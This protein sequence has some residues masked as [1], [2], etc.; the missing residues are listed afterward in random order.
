M[1]KLICILFS[2]TV[3]VASMFADK[4]RFYEGGK[5]IDTM[6]V[7]SE[8][9]LKVRVKSNRLCGLPHR[10]PVKVVAIGK[11]ETIDGITAP[12]VEILIPRY[13]C[14]E[15]E[16]PRYG[17]IFGG[18]LSS[19]QAE[20]STKNWKKKDYENYLLNFCS[21]Q[22]EHDDYIFEIYV[23]FFDAKNL[24]RTEYIDGEDG[25]WSVSE[26]NGNS[27]ILKLEYTKNEHY[28]DPD[29]PEA[30]RV[31][32][33]KTIE[34]KMK[35]IDEAHYF[36]E[37]LNKN[38]YGLIAGASETKVSFYLKD[39]NGRSIYDYVGKILNTAD[40][41]R[42]NQSVAIKCGVSVKDTKYERQCHDYWNPI[43]VEHQKKADEMK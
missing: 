38:F 34:H 8:D 1:K 29:D 20:F 31:V 21:W 23:G 36:D 22:K 12:W 25:V 5:V 14:R 35:I 18:Y 9:G 40:A 24:S 7:N 28:F 42:A 13:E 10:L 33:Y 26:Y 41:W 17:W 39:S 2:F 30:Y 15:E 3:F 32:V 16:V 43:M 4:S 27:F 19:K 6:Y 11:E 37:T